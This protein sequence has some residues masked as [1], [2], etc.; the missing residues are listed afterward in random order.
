MTLYLYQ[1]TIHNIRSKCK[2]VNIN[3]NGTSQFWDYLLKTRQMQF[4]NRQIS[5]P[6]VLKVI[7]NIE[8]IYQCYQ[9]IQNIP[10]LRKKSE[11]NIDYNNESIIHLLVLYLMSECIMNINT[12][13]DYLYKKNNKEYLD[14]LKDEYF[15]I[16]NIYNLIENDNL[17]ELLDSN[18]K[19]DCDYI[20]N[21]CIQSFHNK[22]TELCQKLIQLK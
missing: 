8:I 9:M 6:N 14:Q 7:I 16:L 21:Q 22:L 2:I 15:S 12:N 11:I 13:Y 19:E 1:Q 18:E 10:K 20:F 3:A 4:I 5:N 17:T